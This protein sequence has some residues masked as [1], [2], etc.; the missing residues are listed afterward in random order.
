M[1]VDTPA[2]RPHYFV[3]G[4]FEKKQLL[5]FN[6]AQEVALFHDVSYFDKLLSAAKV[7]TE[8]V[9][10]IKVPKSMH[11]CAVF[12][13]FSQVQCTFSAFCINRC[14]I[15]ETA[16]TICRCNIPWKNDILL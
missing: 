12:N 4:L 6:L 9:N 15:S 8:K 11:I 16:A 14:A 3:H 13:D 10:V 7:R 2:M 5:L 1:G